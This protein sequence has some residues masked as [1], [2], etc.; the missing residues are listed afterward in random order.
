MGIFSK[1]NK[2]GEDGH[3]R[4]NSKNNDLKIT[5]EDER[6][7]KT[8]S[9]NL[10]DPI[11]DAVNEAQP[12]EEA[13]MHN[14]SSSIGNGVLNDI[15]GN[16]IVNPDISNPTRSRDERPMDTIR[17]FEYSITGDPIYQEQ[18]ET[19]ILG[20]RV[21]DDFPLGNG[22]AANNQ[23]QYDEYGQPIYT[24]NRA[25]Q[26]IVEQGVYSAPPPKIEEQ[27]K[28]KFFSFGK[29]KKEAAA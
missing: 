22:Y 24:N 11:L 13:N 12:F 28:K 21:R 15:F 8:R 26:P 2:D 16:K 18:L 14:R 20:W 23:V 6:R 9:Q 5:D 7:M 27:K 3:K 1:K 17:S 25:N 10:H 19:H 4:S 29:K